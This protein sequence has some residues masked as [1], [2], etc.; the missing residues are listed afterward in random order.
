MCDSQLPIPAPQAGIFIYM[1]KILFI[2]ATHGD[3]GFSVNLMR[4]I[5]QQYPRNIFSYDWVIGNPK[6]YARNVRFLDSDLNRSA[7]GYSESPS[8]EVRRA[9]EIM[10]LCRAYEYVIDVHGSTSNVGITTITTNPTVQNLFFAS[11]LPIDKKVIWYSKKSLQSGPLTQFMKCPAI[12]LEC[13]P[14]DSPEMWAELSKTIAN[15]LENTQNK[16]R[17]K[18]ALCLSPEGEFF[19][20]YGK[21]L[22]AV[23][24]LTDFK[25]A[26]VGKEVF[27]PFLSYQYSD[28]SC[29]KT[30]KISIKNYF[31][32]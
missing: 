8:Y 27:Y 21:L 11:W 9:K 5:S 24:G 26:T 32:Y 15:I 23:N 13:G 28:I 18:T 19:V 22:R 1:K 4:Q 6:A 17:K 31:L 2:V 30:R 14:K 3:E 12:E 10:E 7:P 20:V 25:R 29:Y 16:K